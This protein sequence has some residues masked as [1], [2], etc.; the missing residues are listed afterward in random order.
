M[1]L[2]AALL[3]FVCA[4]YACG[5]GGGGTSSPEPVAPLPHRAG[6]HY[7]FYGTWD[8]LQVGETAAFIDFAWVMASPVGI[9]QL[10]EAQARGV[11]FGVADVMWQ[12][13]RATDRKTDRGDVA[14]EPN[15]DAAG[16]LRAFLAD[17]SNVAM[18]PMLT[19]IYPIDEPDLHGL[20]DEQVCA[21]NA[22]VRSVAAEF[23]VAPKLLVI[24]GDR[25][26]PCIGSYDAVGRDEYGNVSR[27]LAMVD[28]LQLR[29]DQQRIL[30]PGGACPYMND[31]Q[32]FLAKAET[33]VTVGWVVAFLWTDYAAPNGTPQCGIRNN[34]TRAK[35]EALGTTILAK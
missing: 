33:D 22:L 21:T 1:R 5:G 18:L 15:P 29:P 12:V 25:G 31:P 13:Y 32:P 34:P 28:A 23:K 20:T 35:Y 26:T 8:A 9:T 3:V 7:G 14:F 4:L 10:Q 6:I 17:M 2:L 16:N 30:V 11:K 19:A 27:A 24:Y